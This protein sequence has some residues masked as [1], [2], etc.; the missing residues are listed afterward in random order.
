A[1][2]GYSLFP[3]QPGPG[4]PAR[5]VAAWMPS[6][7]P[8]RLDPRG[9]SD[10]G[11]I[12]PPGPHRHPADAVAAPPARG[13]SPVARRPA[14][15]QP[16]PCRCPSRPHRSARGDLRGARAADLSRPVVLLAGARRPVRT[17]VH[18]LQAADDVS[19]VR[20]LDRADLERPRGPARHA[21]RPAAAGGP[22]RRAA[23]AR[24]CP[25]RADEPGRAPPGTAGDCRPIVAADRGL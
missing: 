10:P 21:V 3:G 5:P 8:T 12:D 19:P 1:C 23:A 16:R 7:D 9:R 18:D 24:Q 15:A 20:A 14:G 6:Y 2:P 13:A 11:S 4:T 25:P 17:R 22:P